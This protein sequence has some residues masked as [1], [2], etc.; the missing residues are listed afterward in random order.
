VSQALTHSG[1]VTSAASM[2]AKVNNNQ[3]KVMFNAWLA[4]FLYDISATDVTLIN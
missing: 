4:Y 2:V 3:T 1:N